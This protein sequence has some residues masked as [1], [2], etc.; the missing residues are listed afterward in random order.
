MKKVQHSV[1]NEIFTCYHL[2]ASSFIEIDWCDCIRIGVGTCTCMYELVCMSHLIRVKKKNEKK[3]NN[4]LHKTNISVHSS[5]GVV[6]FQIFWDWCAILI[7]SMHIPNGQAHS[8][9]S[10]HHFFLFILLRFV[11]FHFCFVLFIFLIAII[12][13]LKRINSKHTQSIKTK[14][15]VYTNHAF[16]SQRTR[17]WSFF[18]ANNSQVELDFMH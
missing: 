11:S 17:F 13:E 6:L 12:T 18:S 7:L 3:E 4:Y 8:L 16:A 10:N 1:P 14:K 9:I 15:W 5:H 2:M